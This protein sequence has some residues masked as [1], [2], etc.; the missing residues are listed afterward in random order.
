MT[1][2]LSPDE[3]S[4]LCEDFLKLFDCQTRHHKQ[5]VPCL[6]G[7]SNSGKTSLFMATNRIIDPSKVAR[8]TKQR[9]F[10]KAMIDEDTELINLDEARVEL[11]EIDDWKIIT[12]GGWTAHD[13]KWKTAK[14]F[15]NKAPIFI[16]CQKE[17][18]FGSTE[19]NEAMNNRLNKYKFKTLPVVDKEAAKWIKDHPMDCITWAAL[20]CP[21]PQL[22]D[23]NVIDCMAENQGL[24]LEDKQA[25][26]SLDLDKEPIINRTTAPEHLEIPRALSSDEEG[27]DEKIQLLKRAMESSEHNVGKVRMLEDLI[28]QLKQDNRAWRQR[29]VEHEQR[30]HGQHKEH[31]R[32]IGV[33]EELLD[34]LP[35]DP[36]V[37]PVP[38]E[39]QQEITA[40]VA[41]QKTV[42]E[43]REKARVKDL[44]TSQWLINKEKQMVDLQLQVEHCPL[45]KVKKAKEYLLSTCVDAIKAFHVQ[46]KTPLDLGVKF[47]KEMLIQHDLF[48]MIHVSLVDS[49]H[50]PLTLIHADSEEDKDSKEGE[51]SGEEIFMTPPRKRPAQ[52]DEDPEPK[53]TKSA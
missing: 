2:S 18:D 42:A 32:G 52:S 21:A 13:R 35:M 50:A 36:S 10:N 53:R 1:N 17:L 26:L 5:R 12:Q 43:E 29:M 30:R 39:L 22:D 51:D 15:L 37:N 11:M 16:T 14:G 48:K 19:D 8:V 38:T 47:R 27:E 46:K 23:H 34:L 25:I 31:L 24:S 4:S 41:E 33:N 6:I 40:K 28:R 44:F 49:L 45:G 20:Q 9:E 3:V 7:P